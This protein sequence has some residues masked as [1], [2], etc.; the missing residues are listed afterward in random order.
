MRTGTARLGAGREAGIVGRE[1]VGRGERI[2]G[3]ISHSAVVQFWCGATHSRV[4]RAAKLE[5]IT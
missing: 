4:Q 3:H 2:A 1:E 5:Y